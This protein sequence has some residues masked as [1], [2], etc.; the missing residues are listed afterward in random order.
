[1][2]K[3]MR[4]AATASAQPYGLGSSQPTRATKLGNNARKNSMAHKW[5]SMVRPSSL[6][7]GDGQGDCCVRLRALLWY[8]IRRRR[9]S[10]RAFAPRLGQAAPAE[11]VLAGCCPHAV[12]GHMLVVTP[13]KLWR[14]RKLRHEWQAQGAQVKT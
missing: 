13:K 10:Q 14:D 7:V 5:A 3:A 4:Q 9:G 6:R 1:M 12:L 8:A 2:H 11:G